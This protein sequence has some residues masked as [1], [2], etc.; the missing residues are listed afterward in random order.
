MIDP[1]EITNFKRTNS[2]LEELLLF[3]LAVAGKT[4]KQIASSLEKFLDTN[5]SYYLDHTW[6]L[7]EFG[8]QELVVIR[9]PQEM[10]PFAK[11]RWLEHHKRL[12][13]AIR[14]SKLG[15]HT[16]LLHAF[17]EV[18]NRKFDL[19]RVTPQELETVK[20][21]GPKTSRFFIL[22]SRKTNDIACLDTHV[23]KYLKGLGHDV[24]KNRPTGKAYERLEKAFILHA[25][26]LKV[27][28]YEL[29]LQIWNKLSRSGKG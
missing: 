10:S 14:E 22:H 17:R 24:P 13:E 1:T 20:G 4:A 5:S 26:K 25:K 27:P 12:V 3:C 11:V 9:P 21:I 16:K 19:R 18:A 23:L 8:G 2:E 29:D 7:K 15:Q 6:Q 28:T